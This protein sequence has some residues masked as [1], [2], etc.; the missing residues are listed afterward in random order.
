MHCRSE[1]PGSGATLLRTRTS[2][3]SVHLKRTGCSMVNG[4]GFFS[5]ATRIRSGLLGSSALVRFSYWSRSHTETHPCCPT[6]VH[7]T[8]SSRQVCRVE[9]GCGTMTREK[10]PP[11]STESPSSR[12]RMYVLAILVKY[13]MQNV[14]S[15]SV[16]AG[17]IVRS[18]L[19]QRMLNTRSSSVRLKTSA[20]ILLLKR[21]R[22]WTI[23]TPS[24][25]TVPFSCCRSSKQYSTASSPGSGVRMYTGSSNGSSYS[26][27]Q[28]PFTNDLKMYL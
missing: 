28:F 19:S 10:G 8:G 15:S 6:I 18:S 20:L 11:G 13:V 24:T 21:S 22:L 25:P 12:L 27:P 16:V 14:E 17:L 26:M 9:G 23:M 3:L 5:W 7:G 4:S 1:M 2:T